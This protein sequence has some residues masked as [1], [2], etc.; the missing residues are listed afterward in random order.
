MIKKENQ[1]SL[2]PRNTQLK[3]NFVTSIII[4]FA[5]VLSVN[6]A[7]PKLVVGIVIDG[8]E[9]EKIDVLSPFLKE[10]GFNRFLKEGVIIDNV[11]FGSNLDAT[12][13]TAV[14]MTGS[15]PRINGIGS[16]RYYDPVARRTVD[17][18]EEGEG[19][20]GGFS[21]ILSP[22]ALRV[23]TITDEARISGGGLTYA[24]SIAP[25]SSIA[26]VLGAHA[27][28]SAVWFDEHKGK[29]SS[30]NFY[31]ELPYEAMTS[32]RTNYLINTVDT[33]IWT[34]S[35]ETVATALLPDLLTHYPFRYSFNALTSDRM[36]KFADSPLLNREITNLAIQYLKGQEL[37]RHDGLDVL[38]LSYTLKPYEYSKNAENRYELYDS[39]I[40]LDNSLSQLF[41]EIDNTLGKENVVIYV[42]GTP[43]QMQRRK[44]EERWNI[45]GGEF[46][47]KKAISLLNLYLIALYGNGEWVTAYNEGNF[48]LNKELAASKDIDLNVLRRQ[49]ADF[50]IR[51]AGVG[52]AY[53]IDDIVSIA[54]NVPNGD[55]RFR[56]TVLEHSGD[57]FV[58]LIPGWT[59][60]DDYNI[61]GSN[62][63][64]VAASGATTAPFF[65]TGP[66]LSVRRVQ[67]VIDARA[68][69]PG[70]ARTLHIRSPNGAG[71]P[72]FLF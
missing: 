59:M 1:N 8:L 28:N 44:D 62:S 37:G 2:Y 26:L 12:A 55:G 33:A 3:R 65:I 35:P 71:T 31:K 22:N 9:Q 49:S 43:S 48:Y 29:W 13:A 46:S 52:Y 51:M 42:S 18:F 54:P 7:Q 20:T 58:E 39:Y 27:G 45:P 4:T 69:A 47:S 53:T 57:V 50:L 67:T 21:R 6:A 11:D 61:E 41:T 17:A 66:D 60:T 72:P 32:N 19:G 24:H 34:P 70:L 14:L 68:I 30:T 5:T 38:N 15:S 63:E 40:K 10:N 23:S 36:A 64:H 56:N 25:N 16:A